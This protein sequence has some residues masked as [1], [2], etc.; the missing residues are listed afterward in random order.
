MRCFGYI[1]SCSGETVYFS[2]DSKSVPPCV[3]EAFMNG[4]IDEIY[5]DSSLETGDHA[6]H[7]SFK[8]LK[9]T[10]APEFRSRVYCIHLDKD[11]RETI[12][13]AGFK[14]PEFNT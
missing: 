7:G 12:L 10:F 8:E 9:D 1:V 4:K 11:Y 5:Q 14:V 13:A 2:G 6:T 3:T